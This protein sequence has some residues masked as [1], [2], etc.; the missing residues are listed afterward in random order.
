[1]RSIRDDKNL[2]G[3]TVLLRADLDAPH[4]NGRIL[5]HYRLEMALPTIQFLQSAGVKV[6]II[7]KSGQ[8]KE[9]D[10]ETESL[11]AQATWL[12]AALG[13]KLIVTEGRLP[14]Y[15]APHF[16][17][18]K[19]DIR[20]EENIA[21]VKAI[22]MKD[23]VLLDNIRFYSEEK[24]LDREFSQKLASLGDIYVGDAFAMVHRNE[25]SVALLPSLLPS[26]AG[27]NLGKEVKALETLLESKLSP[28]IL[29][30]GGAKISDKVGVIR[31]LAKKADSIL[32]GGGP[33]NLFF[34]AKGLEIG[35]SIREKEAL[36]LAKELLRNFK[37]KIVLPEDVLVA[38]PESYE[39][40]RYCLAGDVKKD[41]AILDIGPKTILNFAKRIKQAKKMVWSGPLGYFEK[42]SFSHGTF[43]LAIIFAARSRGS[44]FGLVGGG[45][46]AEAFALAKVREQVD[47]VSTAGSATLD[48]LAGQTLPGLS[49]LGYKRP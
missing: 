15:D 48:F 38:D 46:T 27:L 31:N 22:P 5:D 45:D 25:T 12:A 47:F 28:F 9:G 23:I 43:S 32:I 2:K 21:L 1:M 8:P 14:D 19:G 11:L 7:S 44:A 17:F 49:A 24:G 29:I 33:A 13:R 40:V 42:P 30:I 36:D 35:K 16:V 26:Y 20:K 41:E 4:L 6:V 18:F 34:L 10:R 39:R 37:D 3:R